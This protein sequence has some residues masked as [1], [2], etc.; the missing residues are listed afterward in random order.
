MGQ[1]V[2]SASSS[3]RNSTP[4]TSAAAAASSSPHHTSEANN[5]EESRRHASSPSSSSTNDATTNLIR[6][7]SRSSALIELETNYNYPGS[8]EAE[9]AAEID[10]VTTRHDAIRRVVQKY[11]REECHHPTI[12]SPEHGWTVVPVYNSEDK[13]RIWKRKAPEN[14]RAFEFAIKGTTTVP[15]HV[16]FDTAIWNLR[17][18]REWDQSC[19]EAAL[20][21]KDE[22]TGC[23]FS[24]PPGVRIDETLRD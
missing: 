20:V 18:R 24:L 15:P 13:I 10:R 5:Q 16:F 6:R 1:I 7:F 19:G 23:V 12:G 21:E 4:F 2:A 22:R 17:E 11:A 8:H 14:E 3:R 9:D